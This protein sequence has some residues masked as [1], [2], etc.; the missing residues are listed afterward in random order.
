MWPL[1]LGRRSR[2][3]VPDTSPTSYSVAP[4]TSAVTLCC[5]FHV[6]VL[7]PRP[8]GPARLQPARCP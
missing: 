3:A 6:P 7:R 4:P 1:K 2:F 5:S 8:A